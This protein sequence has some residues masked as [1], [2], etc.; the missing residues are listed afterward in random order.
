MKKGNLA[1]VSM[2]FVKPEDT[3]LQERILSTMKAFTDRGYPVYVADGGSPDEFVRNIKGLGVNVITKE[4]LIECYGQHPKLP[5]QHK[6]AY[7]AA[8]DDGAEHCLYS[9]PD[10]KEWA[11]SGNLELA[12]KQYFNE[13][14]EHGEIARTPEQMQTFPA[15]Q[16][17]TE[18]IL[19][20]QLGLWTGVEGDY[21]YGP[22]ISSKG[23]IETIDHIP[24][25]PSLGWATVTW[26]PIIA[27]M[28]GMKLGMLNYGLGCPTEQQTEVT[29]EDVE[30]R[31][32]QGRDNL[33]GINTAVALGI[34]SELDRIGILNQY[35]QRNVDI[36]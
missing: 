31:L 3:A 5:G 28:R 34:E 16:Q 9:E 13:Q 33:M 8:L 7:F 27:T 18:G 25:N 23:L 1:I 26:L 36:K 17:I 14:L 24:N 4:E 19:N 10:K 30:Y 12:V 35:I 21:I 15:A 32:K 22:Q 29:Q 20:K 2:S 6:S 11:E